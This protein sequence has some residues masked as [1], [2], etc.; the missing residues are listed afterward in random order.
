[1][2]KRMTKPIGV[3]GGMGPLATKAFFG[4]VI[5]NTDATCDQEHINMIILNHATMPDRT[6][7]LLS[8]DTELLFS[9]LLSD[10]I[11]L[12]KSGASHIAIPCN[13][14]HAFVRKLQEYIGIPIIN[15]IQA[16]VEDIVTSKG[17]GIK[18]GILATDGTVKLSLYQDEMKKQGLIPF[19]PSA[20]NQKRVM[21]II[22]DGIKKG[23]DVNYEDFAA[24]EKELFEKGCGCAIMGCT[25]MSCFKEMYDLSDNFYF[26]A[27]K[28]LAM[29]TI[30]AA[31]AKKRVKRRY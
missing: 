20:E 15:M 10:C 5:D 26:D 2:G 22:Y 14:S 9:N 7:A 6:N 25:E 19:V 1:M 17:T 31:G 28:S 30:E 13:T 29:K 11:F 16:A 21:R 12:E 4:M 24:I 23:G 3:L 27:M 8:G 18:A